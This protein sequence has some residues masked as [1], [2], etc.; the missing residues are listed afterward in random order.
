MT[1][2]PC[3]TCDG[4]GWVTDARHQI[5]YVKCRACKGTG[6]QIRADLELMA[7]ALSTPTSRNVA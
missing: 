6:D 3:M 4:E 5:G 2:R 1:D 7:D